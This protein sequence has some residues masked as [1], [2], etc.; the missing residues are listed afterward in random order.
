MYTMVRLACLSVSTVSN[1][2]LAK[3]VSVHVLGNDI[4][5]VG[6]YW[7]WLY[8]P[9]ECRIRQW[10]FWKYKRW[11]RKL[12]SKM[13]DSSL[14]LS[15]IAT[16]PLRR[17]L[18]PHWDP[19]YDSEVALGGK[20]GRVSKLVMP[21]SFRSKITNSILYCPYPYSSHWPNLRSHFWHSTRYIS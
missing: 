10:L 5:M 4:F 21:T 11:S 18:A 17:L 7:Y 2:L 1:W 6:R 8:R 12:T 15:L 20:K 13:N 9:K 16:F 14:S 3:M 19:L